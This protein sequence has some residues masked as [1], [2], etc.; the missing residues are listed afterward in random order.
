MEDDNI[1][2]TKMGKEEFE[3]MFGNFDE[4]M[5]TIRQEDIK[6]SELEKA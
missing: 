5:E 4:T 6:I 1:D 3:E 2:F